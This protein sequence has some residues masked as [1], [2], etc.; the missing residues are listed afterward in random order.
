MASD[1]GAD[2]DLDVFVDATAGKGI[3]TR[4]GVGKVR[5]LHT[6]TLWVQKLVQDK[7]PRKR[8]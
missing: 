6:F 7:D 8:A 5:H 2:L 4:R 3:A 1:L